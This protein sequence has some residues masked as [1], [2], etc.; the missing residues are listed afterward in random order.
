MKM[1]Y[2]NISYHILYNFHRP[3]IKK[4]GGAPMEII[5]NL[6][7]K[8]VCDRSQDQKVVEIIQ[9]DCMTRITGNPDGTLN[10]E[11][12]RIPSAA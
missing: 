9:K 4:K 1:Q 10:I 3:Q 6:N 8:R 5:K 12:I 7:N 11:H 2:L